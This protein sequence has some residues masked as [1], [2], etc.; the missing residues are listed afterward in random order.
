MCRA[1]TVVADLE[2]KDYSWVG[3][4]YTLASTAFIPFSKFL[5]A[6]LD[7]LELTRL[8][9]AAGM[10]TIFGRRAVMVSAILIFALGSVLCGAAQS[11]TMMIIGRT[12]GKCN[13][14]SVLQ[15]SLADH[16]HP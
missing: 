2:M 8:F 9:T 10:A 3:S 12:I 4:A 6:F 11:S 7:D 1:R 13:G 5:V 16:K 15:R 14:V